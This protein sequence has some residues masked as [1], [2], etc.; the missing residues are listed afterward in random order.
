MEKIILPSSS[1]NQGEADLSLL[2][3]MDCY[4]YLWSKWNGAQLLI[5]QRNGPK[6]LSR[7]P[8]RRQYFLNADLVDEMISP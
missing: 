6:T 4:Q 8:F 1:N 2:A 5:Q 7:L 3:R